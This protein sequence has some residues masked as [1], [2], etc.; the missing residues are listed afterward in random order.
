[1]IMQ[2]TPGF[3]EET[4][5]SLA[6][7]VVTLADPLSGDVLESLDLPDTQWIHG[8]LLPFPGLV[9][10][11]GTPGS[12][13][14]FFALWMAI[15]ASNGLPL[16][17]G[18]DG[19]GCLE[20]MGVVPTLFIEEENTLRMLKHRFMQFPKLD[21]SNI[22]FY[23]DA[24]FK[25]K[26]QAWVD[27]ILQVVDKLGI[28]LIFLDPFSSVMGLE[29]ENDN[30][31][32]SKVMDIIRKEF[33]K[34]DIT[35]VLIHH[36]S[37]SANGMPSLRG[38][39]DILGKVDVHLAMNIEDASERLITVKYAKMRLIDSSDLKDFQVRLAGTKGLRDWRFEYVGEKKSDFIEARDDLRGRI[40]TLFEDG[41]SRSR[42][43]VSSA[44]GESNTGKKF[45]DVWNWMIEA[46]LLKKKGKDSFIHKSA[47]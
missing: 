12:Y 36:S 15:R 11:S 10:I 4:L 41:E 37:K 7:P 47:E 13:K 21:G 24:G 16:F 18:E 43:D 20:K 19:V 22:H 40:E 27:R 33:L 44:L 1:M 2:E 39:G 26:E 25:M 45:K 30:A 28:K 5:K 14:T 29:N 31:E 42:K 35:I 46:G 23:V 3:I 32:V 9:A 38:A 34:R 17:D 6:Q 8:T